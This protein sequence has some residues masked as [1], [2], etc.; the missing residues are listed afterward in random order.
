MYISGVPGTGKTATVHAV[1]CHL[2][3][4]ALDKDLPSFCASI[5]LPFF[6]EV[7]GLRLTEPRQAYVRVVQMLMGEKMS[8]EQ[9]HRTL[10]KRFCSS[11]PKMST[12]LLIDEGLTRLVF[13]PYSYQQLQEI[14]MNRLE[15]SSAFHPDAV[16]LVASDARRALDICRRA[17]ELVGS[18]E[19]E[20]ELSDSQTVTVLHVEKCLNQIFT[21]ARVQAI[22][23]TSLMGQYLL[24][25][26]RDETLRT[27]LE[28][29]NLRQVYNHLKAVCALEGVT[30]PTVG[31]VLS[32]CW[33]LAKCGLVLAEK[34][35]SDINKKLSL[36]VSSDDIHYALSC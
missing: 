24:R 14:V 27:G 34:G 18:G 33:T 10:E 36:N 7:N 1:V 15:G 3:K 22:R 17:T 30:M 20:G 28:E 26:I 12:V 8:P 31:E 21:G 16:Q 32:I 5:I 6:V 29:T 13:H 11:K 35:R 19:V 2:Q 9:A 25:S 4:S 23:N